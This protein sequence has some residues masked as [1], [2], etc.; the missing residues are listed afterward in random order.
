M[1]EY[2]K[3]LITTLQNDKTVSPLPED[4]HSREGFSQ[5]KNLTKGRPFQG[6]LAKALKYRFLMRPRSQKSD[7]ECTK[8]TFKI[9][10]ARDLVGKEGRTRDTFCRIE[11][12]DL[13]R[14]RKEKRGKILETETVAGSLAPVWNQHL[15]L[16]TSNPVDAIRVEVWDRPKDYFL[17]QIVLKLSDLVSKSRDGYVKS[18]FP[19]VPRSERGRDKY[20][21]GELLVEAEI[22]EAESTTGGVERMHSDMKMCGVDLRALY[23]SLLRSCMVLDLHIPPDGREHLLSNESVAMLKLWVKFWDISEPAQ[24]IIYVETLFQK[25]M[26]DQIPVTEILNSFNVLYGKVRVSGW[27]HSS[28]VLI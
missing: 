25:F 13:E 18:W 6:I 11:H 8:I 3:A 20:V 5:W 1:H 28:D 10:S 16:E 24:L 26:E 27:L 14:S 12:G 17:G 7:S 21:G 19:L 15:K 9:V 2:V 23:R 4:F 22:Q